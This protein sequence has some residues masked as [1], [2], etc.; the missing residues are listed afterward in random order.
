M[1]K[2]DGTSLLAG[3]WQIPNV[4]GPVTPTVTG[5]S[6]T[7]VETPFG[8]QPLLAEIDESEDLL[9]LHITLG[10]FPMK[11]AR[12]KKDGGSTV[13]AFSNGGKWTK[14]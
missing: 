12:L 9:G 4:D 5:N 6:V 7:S 10:G 1:N 3:K 13:L 2:A 14:L 8:N 11:S